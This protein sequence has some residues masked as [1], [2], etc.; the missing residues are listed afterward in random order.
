MSQPPELRWSDDEAARI[1]REIYGAVLL[2]STSTVAESL[3]DASELAGLP[4]PVIAMALGLGSG[5]D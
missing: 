4:A 1:V 3:Y 5:G 2:D